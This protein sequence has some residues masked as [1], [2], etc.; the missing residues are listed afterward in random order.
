MIRITDS[1]LSLRVWPDSFVEE[2]NLAQNVS[3]LRRSGI[4]NRESWA[5]YEPGSSKVLAMTP[6]FKAYGWNPRSSIYM[7]TSV[8]MRG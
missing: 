8:N 4:W 1:L 5:S 3:A 6:K 2:V 7:A